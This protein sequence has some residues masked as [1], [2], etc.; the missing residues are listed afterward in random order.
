M[1]EQPGKKLFIMAANSKKNI[2]GGTQRGEGQVSHDTVVPISA[3]SFT[4]PAEAGTN[5]ETENIPLSMTGAN[6][7]PAPSGSAVSQIQIPGIKDGRK[8]IGE[9]KP[10]TPN[11]GNPPVVGRKPTGSEPAAPLFLP[12]RGWEEEELELKIRM[13][14]HVDLDEV[15]SVDFGERCTIDTSGIEYGDGKGLVLWSC[16]HYFLYIDGE[17]VVVEQDT[18][19]NV[20]ANYEFG[21]S[22]AVNA[23][24]AS[25]ESVDSDEELEGSQCLP[26]NSPENLNIDSTSENGE[27]VE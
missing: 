19:G 8:G 11:G 27:S 16:K 12:H 15:D 4:H 21:G 9:M 20:L 7:A 2:V 26:A 10:E 22:E 18:L 23:Y 3:S 17:E 5:V 6:G 1:V 14:L 24:L 25:L 13:M